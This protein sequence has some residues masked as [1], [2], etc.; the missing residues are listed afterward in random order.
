VAMSRHSRSRFAYDLVRCR[1]RATS[2][3]A[4]ERIRRHAQPVPLLTVEGVTLTAKQFWS[5]TL[6]DVDTRSLIQN[7]EQRSDRSIPCS[8][9]VARPTRTL[10]PACK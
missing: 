6:Y 5:V 8:G 2:S 7:K 9:E 4:D 10:F 3:V 1:S